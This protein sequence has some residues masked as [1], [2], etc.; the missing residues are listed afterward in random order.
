MQ[1]FL[2]RL[3]LLPAIARSRLRCIALVSVAEGKPCSEAS[4]GIQK[5]RKAQSRLSAA[6]VCKKTIV[7][8]RSLVNKAQ[9]LKTRLRH[10]PP[11]QM[12]AHLHMQNLRYHCCI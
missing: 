6:E 9:T 7:S 1:P 2:K 8:V 10:L 5:W 11:R 12:L 4:S 3:F